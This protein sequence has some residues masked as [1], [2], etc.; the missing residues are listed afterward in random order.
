MYSIKSRPGAGVLA[1]RNGRPWRRAGRI[2]RFAGALAMAVIALSAGVG[3]AQA[4]TAG[5]PRASLAFAP[6]RVSAGSRPVLRFAASDVPAG[7][8]IYLEAAAGVG[9]SWQFVGRIRA[10]SGAVRLPADPVGR[11][12]YRL[13]VTHGDT[14]IVTSGPASLTVTSATPPAS[15]TGS[16]CVACQAANDVIPWLTPIVAPVVA[17]VAQQ[18]GSAF[19]AFLAFIFG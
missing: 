6:A 9:Q 7:S 5:G 14:V 10:R 1:G 15:G 18:V 17:S 4:A 3:V 12:E 16:G 8:V 11:Y 19:L 13:L 2:T